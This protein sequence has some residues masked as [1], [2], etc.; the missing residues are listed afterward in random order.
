MV[1]KRC[2]KN[3]PEDSEFCQYCGNKLEQGFVIS[4]DVIEK[5]KKVELTVVDN[6]PNI[7]DMTPKEAAEYLI[8]LQMNEPYQ[9]QDSS[10]FKNKPKAKTRF[11]S[12]CGS[13]V[14]NETKVCTGCGKK[15]FKGIA[16]NKFSITATVLSLVIITVS[17]LCVLQYSKTQKLQ[18]DIEYLELQN[19]NKQT[20]INRLN[21]EIDDLERDVTNYIDLAN[22]V[23]ECVV[24]IEDDGTN[25]YH[26]YE[27]S[28]FKGEGF[29]AFNVETAK[30]RGYKECPQCH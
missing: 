14:D 30:V 13:I 18:K 16:F 19:S 22:F 20:T 1:C 24:F 7:D 10:D 29:W 12:Y 5:S 28:R 17:T 25:L 2:N 4:T 23:D 6:G 26:K 21:D 15:Y 11:C 27:C 8:S 3:L 9:K